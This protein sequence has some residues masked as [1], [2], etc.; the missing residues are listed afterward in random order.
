MARPRGAGPYFIEAVTY[1][2]G[3]HTT[4]DDAARY[5]QPDTV[6][7]HWR[8]EPVAR[9]RD[10]LVGRRYWGKAEEEQLVS[11]CQRQVE[12]AVD[13]YLSVGARA[14]ESMFDQLY[15]ELPAVYAVQR[16]ELCEKPHGDSDAG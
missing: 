2:L 12:I 3:D 9:L 1:R 7:E 8:E 11:E 6:R 15:A 4:A 16:Q 14:P 13:T 5:R 10:Y